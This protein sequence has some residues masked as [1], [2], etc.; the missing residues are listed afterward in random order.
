MIPSLFV[1]SL[2]TTVG[3]GVATVSIIAESLPS[4]DIFPALSVITAFTSIV[5]PS[6]GAGYFGCFELGGNAAER[7]IT[8]ANTSGTAFNGTLGDGT[9]SPLGLANQATW[10]SPITAIG[11][12]FRGGDYVN[13]F[14]RVQTS[15]RASVTTVDAS[16]SYNYGGRGVR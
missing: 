8:T 12:G 10:P 9:I 3:A 6:A 14:A 13:V 1:S 15:D 5:S 16:R 2:I 4:G 11:V 7:V